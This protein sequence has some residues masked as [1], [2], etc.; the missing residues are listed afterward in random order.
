MPDVSPINLPTDPLPG[1]RISLQRI[2]A[3]RD[4]IDPVFLNAPQFA[5]EPLSAALGCELTLKLET[6]NP[7]RCFKGR[8]ASFLVSTRADAGAFDGRP[9]VAASAGNWGQAVAYACRAR[10]IPL[11]LFAAETANPLKVDLMRALGADMKLA[12]ADFDAAKDAAAAYTAEQN[13]VMLVDGLDVASCEG[14]GTMAVELMAGSTV[15]DVVVV[16][17]GNGAMLNGIARWVKAVAPATDVVAVQASGADAMEASWRQGEV[18]VRDKA[19][20]IADGIGVRVP[21]PEAVDDMRG[22][23]DDVMLVEDETIIQGMKMMMR[24]AGLVTEPSGAVGIAALL[25]DRKRF[26]GRRVATIICGSN[27]APGDVHLLLD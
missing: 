3:A 12:G 8:G 13:G 24:H 17:L 27:V 10:N 25:T 18:I 23:V 6:A 5:C 19:E 20:T 26:A 16:P 7:I 22:I 21:V 14:A 2:A 1:H 4:I 11:T 15:P 9:V